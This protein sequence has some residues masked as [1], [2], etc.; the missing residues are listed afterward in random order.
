MPVSQNYENPL[1]PT[2]FEGLIL[3]KNLISFPKTDSSYLKL[4]ESIFFARK[5]TFIATLVVLEFDNNEMLSNFKT[6]NFFSKADKLLSS[7]F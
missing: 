6:I 4:K 3:K 5:R 1:Q 7:L 2:T